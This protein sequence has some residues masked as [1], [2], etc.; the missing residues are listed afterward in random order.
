MSCFRDFEERLGVRRE[1]SCFRGLNADLD[2]FRSPMVT[3]PD[4][5]SMSRAAATGI[6]QEIIEDGD[7]A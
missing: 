1:I 4:A 5:I 7:L 2:G 6:R 3:Y